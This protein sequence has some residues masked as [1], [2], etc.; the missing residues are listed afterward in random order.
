MKNPSAFRT[1]KPLFVA[2]GSRLA[3]AVRTCSSQ[4]TQRVL[5]VGMK[6]VG[7][8]GVL[9]VHKAIN[10]CH[11]DGRTSGFIELRQV[12]RPRPSPPYPYPSRS[13]LL[14]QE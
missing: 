6:E 7:D 12:G 13:G 5:E 10:C 2:E 3:S 4:I 1:S 11:D 14:S 9:T 8:T